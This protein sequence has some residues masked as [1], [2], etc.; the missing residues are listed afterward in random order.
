VIWYRTLALFVGGA[1]ILG[2]LPYWAWQV[3][4]VLFGPDFRP[5]NLVLSA[6]LLAAG[7]S[8]VG[9]TAWAS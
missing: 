6:V 4:L 9:V 3:R 7:I 2:A 5:V 8:L 1:L